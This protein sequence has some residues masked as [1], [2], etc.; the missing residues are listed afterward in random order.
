MT[1]VSIP[2]ANRC[3][4][5]VLAALMSIVGVGCQVTQG[6]AGRGGGRVSVPVQTTT[7]QRIAVQRDV[8]LAGTLLSPDQAKVGSEVAGVVREVLVELGREVRPGDV[9]VRLEPRE[10]QLAFER[11][12][13]A[14]RQTEA[15]LG[16]DRSQSQRLPADEDIA[17]VRTAVASRDDARAQ[18]SRAQLLAGRG[19]L[20]P[21]ELENAQTRVKVAEANYMAALDLARS[22]EASLEDRRAAYELARKKLNDAVVR[23]PVAGSVAERL[24]QP[25]EFIREDTPVVTLVQMNPLKL[26]TELQERYTGAIRPNLAVD[27]NVESF[28]GSVFHGKVAYVSPVVDQVTRSFVVEVTVDNTDRRLKPGN[29]AKGV[30][31]VREDTKVMAV[32]EDAV[33][34]LAGVSAVFVVENG[35]ARQQVVTLGAHQGTLY[36]VVDGLKGDEVLASSNLGQLATGVQVDVGRTG[37]RQPGRADPVAGGAPRGQRRSS[38]EGASQPGVRR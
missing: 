7:I 11:A 37:T 25:G 24:V 22:L 34:T 3:C 15:Q 14:L 19:L 20:A 17:A 21:V 16:I 6:Q 32:P 35:K 18:L 2:R 38:P 12:E 5:A 10:L 31:V 33:S 13:S 23:A 4:V 8:E 28:P 36:E 9:L 29:F 26:R 1:S 27:F 30:V